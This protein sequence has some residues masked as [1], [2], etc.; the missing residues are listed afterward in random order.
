MTNFKTNN[1]CL[2]HGHG[3]ETYIFSKLCF[4]FLS[5]NEGNP[6]YYSGVKPNH[7]SLLRFAEGS[8]LFVHAS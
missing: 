7:T 6:Y 1:C 4:C 2:P 5:G 8:A 3:L